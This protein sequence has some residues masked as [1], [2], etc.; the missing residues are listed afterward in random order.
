LSV[1]EKVPHKVGCLHSFIKDRKV[2]S[3]QVVF[4]SCMSE[5]WGCLPSTDF[6]CSFVP[7]ITSEGYCYT[8]PF[9]WAP[10]LKAK[11]NCPIQPISLGAQLP[12]TMGTTNSSISL[13]TAE[14]RGSKRK[15]EM[16]RAKLCY[17]PANILL[18]IYPSLAPGKF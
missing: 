17:Y 4:W 11:C 12:H 15:G 6:W 10:F 5:K 14:V 16:L 18:H 9:S 2:I 1:L 7:Q 8:G 13:C 3:C